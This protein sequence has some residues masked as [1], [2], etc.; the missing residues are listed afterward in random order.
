MGNWPERVIQI[1]EGRF[2]RGFADWMIHRLNV[3]DRFGGRIVVAAPRPSGGA[4]VESLNRQDG[5][6][7]VWLRGIYHGELVDRTEVVSSISRAIDPS[8]QWADFLACATDPQ[9]EI[10]LSNTTESGIAYHPE[11]HE[12]HAPA[13]SFPAKVTAYL[14]HRFRHFAGD[15]AAGMIVVPCELIPHN[16]DELRGIVLQHAKDWRLP[17][18]FSDWVEQSNTFC[19]T[20]VDRIVTGMPDGAL[21]DRT[22]SKLGYD[23]ELVTVGEPF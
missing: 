13:S 1:G 15:A 3:Q 14:H 20:L 12:E 7:T 18:R 21:W 10:L 17:E 8:S 22:G 16:G 2:L 6:Y 9:I 5:L 23:D 4:T 11:R 19:N